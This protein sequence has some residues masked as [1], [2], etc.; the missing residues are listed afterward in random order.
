M[1]LLEESLRWFV[2]EQ[3][4]LACLSV[5]GGDRH[6]QIHV[7]GGRIREKEA[8]GEDV[9]LPENAL[10]DLASLTKLFTALTV[11]RLREE[12]LL[13]LE[14]PVT[15]Y[16][17][18][19]AGLSEISVE[20]LLTFG[21]ALK[22]PSRIDDQPDREAGLSQLFHVAASSH[23]AGRIYS[24]MHAMVLKYVIEGAS[25]EA[26][27]DC[28]QR[29]IL[30]PLGMTDT[31]AS[32]PPA[33]RWRAASCDL[34]HRISGDSWQVRTGIEPGTVHDPKARLL[35]Q[36]GR[37]LCGHAG[38]FSTRAD[39]VRFCQGVLKLDVVS[40]E[41]LRLMAR[42]RTGHPLPGGGYT[43][44]LGCQCYVKHPQQ[45]FSEIPVY[46]SDQAFGLSGFTGHHLA[47]DPERGVFSL[48]LGD[49]VL[50]RLTVLVPAPGVSLT[51]LGLD[52]AGYGH[53]RWPNGRTV[54]SSVDYVHQKDARLH[55]PL[56]QA[57][58]L[59]PWHRAGS[60]WP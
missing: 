41:S 45:Y 26:Y 1:T 51:S 15:D 48:F 40:P 44:Y 52:A 32:V 22:T 23:G 55:A 2:E 28:L 30:R 13:T 47:I 20:T 33:Q 57:L 7:E 10:F 56:A 19:F 27:F 4:V 3:R 36:E 21:V 37:D 29:R 12:G 18:Q 25:G 8:S 54:F 38:L 9:P 60:E 14:R 24:D 31:Y 35:S 42:N 59:T 5:T 39:L 46:M 6:S 50:N 34:E 43:Q 49:R 58:G 17:P 16:A 11:L 53:L